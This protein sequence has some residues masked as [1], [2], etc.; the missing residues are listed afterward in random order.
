M[1]WARNLPSVHFLAVFPYRELLKSLL[2]TGGGRKD[3][4]EI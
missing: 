4:R 2:W 3:G 1:V